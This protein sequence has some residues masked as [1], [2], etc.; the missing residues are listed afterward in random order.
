MLKRYQ[1]ICH[2]LYEKTLLLKNQYNKQREK[3][4]LTDEQS[5]TKNQ[6]RLNEIE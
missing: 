3:T 6:Q 2:Q 1:K 5:K 4:Q